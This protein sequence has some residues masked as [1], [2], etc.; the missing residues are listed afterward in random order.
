[1]IRFESLIFALISLALTTNLIYFSFF[2]FLFLKWGN[3]LEPKNLIKGATIA[4]KKILN[5]RGKITS[6]FFKNFRK[7]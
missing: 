6:I 5:K 7:R 4:L 3:G 2:F 1:M